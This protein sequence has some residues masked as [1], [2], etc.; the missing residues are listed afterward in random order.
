MSFKAEALLLSVGKNTALLIEL[1]AVFKTAIRLFDGFAM[2]VRV[3]F[4]KGDDECP[5][6]F[7]A[8]AKVLRKFRKIQIFFS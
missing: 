3:L 5:E 8:A 7:E 2:S 4:P 6:A 1:V